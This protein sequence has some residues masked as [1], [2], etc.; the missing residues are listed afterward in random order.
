VAG[1]LNLVTGLRA[2]ELCDVHL[3]LGV[4]DTGGQSVSAMVGLCPG[5]PSESAGIVGRT[6]RDVFAVQ[7]GMSAKAPHQV[8]R[9]QRALALAAG[10]STLG[11][12]HLRFG[13]GTATSPT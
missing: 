3:S 1:V 13:P 11:W 12:P 7:V 4:I 10:D 5:A 6:L 8:R 2:D 9:L